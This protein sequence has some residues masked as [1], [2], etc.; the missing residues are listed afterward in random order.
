MSLRTRFFLRFPAALVALH[1]QRRAQRSADR[2]RHDHRLL[3][4]D[5]PGLRHR[6]RRGLGDR[7]PGSPG[8]VRAGP[9]PRGRGRA[10]RSRVRRHGGRRARHPVGRRLRDRRRSVAGIAGQRLTNPPAPRL[11]TASGPCGPPSRCTCAATAQGCTA[12]RGPVT[13][14]PWSASARTLGA[15]GRARFIRRRSRSA[16]RAGGAWQVSSSACLSCTCSIRQGRLGRC[17]RSSRGSSSWAQSGSP[18]SGGGPGSPA[19]G[20]GSRRRRWARPNGSGN[21]EAVS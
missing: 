14:R 15:K 2:R 1:R 13:V 8:N 5:R 9:G 18:L 20:G 10:A 16:E 12:F 4:T 7:L 21:R 11:P 17:G 19:L 3:R 6:G